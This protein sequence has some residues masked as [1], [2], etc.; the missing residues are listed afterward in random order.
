MCRSVPPDS[1]I[2]SLTPEERTPIMF[3]RPNPPG[4]I[5]ALKVPNDALLNWHC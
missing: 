2:V 1:R 5:P 4:H 3:Y